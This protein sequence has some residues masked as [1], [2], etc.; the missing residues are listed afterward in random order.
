MAVVFPEPLRP[1]T[2]IVRMSRCALAV[3]TTV[4][5]QLHD[6]FAFD[7]MSVQFVDDLI[8]RDIHVFAGGAG[9][10]YRDMIF[11]CLLKTN[12]ISDG[13]VSSIENS[14]PAPPVTKIFMSTVKEVF[15]FEDTLRRMDIFVG[16]DAADS[17]FMHADVVSDI[18]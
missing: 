12:K 4:R 13:R 2:I 3:G 17:G 10:E 14:Q 5:L 11:W 18:P 16:C 8:N 15:Q 7:Q 1:L 9:F 6:L